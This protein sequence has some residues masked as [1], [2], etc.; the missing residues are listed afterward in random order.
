MSSNEKLITD[1]RRILSKGTA[2]SQDAICAALESLGHPVNQSKVSRLLRKVGAVKTKNKQ[3][4]IVYRLPQEP[5]PP[6]T[7]SQL[8]SLIIDVVANEATIIVCTSPGSAQLVARIL[9]HHKEETGILGTLAGDD[10]IFI[11]PES[12]STI[13]ESTEKIRALLFG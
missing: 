10:S 11:A 6:T 3:G 9:D 1:M 7:S 4:E 8:S 5:A 2:N 13:A 12:L